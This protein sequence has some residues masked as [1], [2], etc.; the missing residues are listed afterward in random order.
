MG[1]W[2]LIIGASA[3]LIWIIVRNTSP[4]GKEML[5]TNCGYKGKPL[6]ESR[7][8]IVIE[9]ILWFIFLIPGLIY[10][11]WRMTNKDTVCPKCKAQ[12][13]IP[14]DSPMAKKFD[15]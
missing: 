15:D 7:G 10:S 9:I 12:H 5:C 14:L 1:E 6:R 11:I 4:Y 8:S 2:I 13:M 3:A